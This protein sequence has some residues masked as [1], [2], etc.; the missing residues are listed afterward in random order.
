MIL[1]S[2]YSNMFGRVCISIISEV[3]MI[4]LGEV[5]MIEQN[6]PVTTFMLLMAASSKVKLRV[7][8]MYRQYMHFFLLQGIGR[9]HRTISKEIKIGTDLYLASEGL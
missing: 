9:F 7:G 8:N 2:Y 3:L 4:K 1:V 6:R 5:L